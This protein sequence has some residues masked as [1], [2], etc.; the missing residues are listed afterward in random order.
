MHRAENVF[1]RELASIF[2]DWGIP[3]AESIITIKKAIPKMN[4]IASG[5]LTNGLDIVKCLAL[6][7]SLSGMASRFL[8]A[9][10]KSPEAAVNTIRLIKTEIQVCM[11]S[12]G[13]AS[14]RDIRKVGMERI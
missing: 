2:K 11:F 10:A 8:Q 4:I 9:A 14:I 6:G 3:T 7:A 5:G 13:M 1:Q 12:S